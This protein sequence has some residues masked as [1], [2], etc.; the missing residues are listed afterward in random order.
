ALLPSSA[1]VLPRLARGL[2]AALARA[3]GRRLGCAPRRLEP[4]G[5]SQRAACGP[6][7][8][9]PAAL[10]GHQLSGRRPAG[11]D[12]LAELP[13]HAAGRDRAPALSGSA[14]RAASGSTPGAAPGTAARAAPGAPR[15]AARR[16]PALGFLRLPLLRSAL[17][18]RGALF[19]SLRVGLSRL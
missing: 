14:R 8:V 19:L 17:P 6:A 4:L 12:P 18:R 3:L 7:A 15:R 2:R 11:A 9:L 16:A 1:R 10:L 13:L 5:S